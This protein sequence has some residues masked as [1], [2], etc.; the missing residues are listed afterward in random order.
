MDDGVLVEFEDCCAPSNMMVDVSELGLDDGGE[1]PSK[2][3]LELSEVTSAFTTIVPFETEL[4]IPSFRDVSFVEFQSNQRHA[5]Y[6]SHTASL[7]I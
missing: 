7:P 2:T 1:V 6:S 3:V 5:E 4:S